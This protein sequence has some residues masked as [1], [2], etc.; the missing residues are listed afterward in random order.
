MSVTCGA[1]LSRARFAAA[2]GMPMPT[3]QTVSL[4]NCRAA[5][6]VMISSAEKPSSGT[7]HLLRRGIYARLELREVLRRHDMAL[8]P[9]KETVSLAGNVIPRLVEAVVALVEALRIGW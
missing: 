5:A 4:V 6:I 3:K 8:H 9:D 7:G 1:W 2:L